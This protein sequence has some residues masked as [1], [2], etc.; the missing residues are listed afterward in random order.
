MIHQLV[1]LLEEKCIRLMHEL[2]LCVQ[3]KFIAVPKR[4]E[5]KIFSFFVFA[6]FLFRDD[7]N[8]CIA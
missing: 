2:K 8:S 7:E 5:R 6:P 1:I 4:L 3:H